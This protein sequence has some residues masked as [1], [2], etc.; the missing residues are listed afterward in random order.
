MLEVGVAVAKVPKY[1]VQESGDSVE[2][3]ERPRGGLSVV[4]S[5]G[6]R[7]G[8]GAKAISNIAV[9]KA[10]SL[11]AEGVRD[12]AVARAAHDYLRTF[13]DGKVSAELILLSVDLETRTLVISR[14]SQCPV[15]LA[16]GGVWR[17][18]DA[19]ASRVGVRTRARP[20]IT[21]LELAARQTAIAFTDGVLHAGARRGLTMDALDVIRRLDCQPACTPQ[22][23]ADGLL[24]AALDLDEGRPRDDITVVV[25]QISEREADHD[26]AVRRMRVHFPI[27][28]L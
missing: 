25:M 7:S 21:E 5:D 4:V 2:V 13:R 28:S 19:P 12:G 18:L 17:V 14:N 9:R 3:I 6:Q 10:A 26:P 20:V 27:S 22:M 15:L 1:A 8:R 24:A 16:E 11:L 23:L